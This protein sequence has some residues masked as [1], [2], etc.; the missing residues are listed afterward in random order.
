MF[1]RYPMWMGRPL[2]QR[3]RLRPPAMAR[4]LLLLMMPR[5]WQRRAAIL[6]WA[7]KHP[8]EHRLDS[9]DWSTVNTNHFATLRTTAESLSA[10][11]ALRLR[12]WSLC[13]ASRLQPSWRKPPYSAVAGRAAPSMRGERPHGGRTAL[14]L[15]RSGC[16]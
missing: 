7:Q 15:Q 10:Y 6:L 12:A 5:L 3:V 2:R 1:V 13:N 4:S 9:F 14:P 8:R 16:C 11:V